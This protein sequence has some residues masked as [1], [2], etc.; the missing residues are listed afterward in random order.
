MGKDTAKGQL[1]TTEGKL[2]MTPRDRGA[3]PER[4]Q[5]LLNCDHSHLLT[6]ALLPGC[7]QVSGK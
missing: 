2:P 5:N 4:G 3:K 6:P 1:G 7:F